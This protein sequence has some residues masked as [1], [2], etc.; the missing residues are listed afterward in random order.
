MLLN[1]GSTRFDAFKIVLNTRDDILAFARALHKKKYIFK[2]F[3]CMTD[4][5]R[6][7]DLRPSFALLS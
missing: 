4:L 5:L 3:Y 1:G 2:Y 6:S 7:A